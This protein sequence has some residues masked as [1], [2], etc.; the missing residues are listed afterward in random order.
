L[1]FGDYL[2]FGTWDLGFSFNG[3]SSQ[4]LPSIYLLIPFYESF[5]NR[6]AKT[7]NEIDRFRRFVMCY[8]FLAKLDDLLLGG[9]LAGFYHDD[10]FYSLT[11][12]LILY[13]D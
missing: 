2:E 9:L 5:P 12:F 3:L 11:P 7:F 8:P 4:T 10:S 1:E 6:S 13:C